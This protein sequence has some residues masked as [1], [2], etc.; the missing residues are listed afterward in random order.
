MAAFM[1]TFSSDQFP[2]SAN[3]RWFVYVGA[4]AAMFV[5]AALSLVPALR[6]VKRINVGQIV[7][8]RAT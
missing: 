7:R 6:A 3:L 8:E 1:N 2:I 5:V 4:A